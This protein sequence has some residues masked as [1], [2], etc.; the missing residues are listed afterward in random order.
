[1]VPA[2][3]I[4]AVYT[5]VDGARPDYVELVRRFAARPD[6]I[7]PE[8]YRDAF[9]LLRYSLRALAKHAPWVRNVYLFTCRPQV[10]AWIA[11]DHPR[12]RLVHHD[13]VVTEPGVLPTFN[14]NV[15]ETYLDRL[16]GISEHFLY[17]NDD[18]L[19][20]APVT[21]DDF[22]APDGRIKVLGTVLGEVVGRRIQEHQWISLGLLEHIP[23]LVERR[24]WREMQHVAADDIA[25]LKRHRFRD[26]HDVRPERL[27]HWHLLRHAR[28]RAVGEPCWRYLPHSAFHKIMRDPAR[29]QKA[30]AKLR[31]RP[32]KF[33]C[34][35]DDQGDHPNPDVVAI[36][37]AFLQEQYPE[38]SPWERISE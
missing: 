20:G 29:E 16:P 5:W 14:S 33:I 4:D 21:R 3:P 31:R 9:E 19:L 17:L 13:E 38:P 28:D 15:I 22:F 11:H 18:Y 34:L 26:P 8:R 2:E 1:M 10:P 32:R 12:I 35:N 30:L 27:Y 7:N 36:V 25:E 6:D 23:T 37:R 24:A